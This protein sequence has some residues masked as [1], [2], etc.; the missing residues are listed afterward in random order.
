MR[1]EI[2][3]LILAAGAS[4]RMGR[5]KQLLVMQGE[6]LLERTIR[7]A[8]AL[9]D[10]VWVVTGSRGP[11]IRFRT[12]CRPHRWVE[13]ERWRDGLSASL[14][15]GLAALP[16][17]SRGVLVLLV[18]QPEVGLFHLSRLIAAATASPDQ[19]VATALAGKPVVPAYLPARMWPA[20][21]RLQGDRGAQALLARSN[22]NLMPCEAAALDLDTPSDWRTWC[23][24]ISRDEI[25][26]HAV[27]LSTL[28]RVPADKL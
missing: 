8:R 13:S 3:V 24:R 21:E 5:A 12:R 4:V 28:E 7:Q 27:S 20:L 19:A 15:A 17:R 23:D 18:D 1:S 14:R 11:L 9:S 22:P 6:T 25:A 10:S 26:R 16:P 2:P